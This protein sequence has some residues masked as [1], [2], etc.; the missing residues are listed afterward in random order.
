LRPEDLAIQIPN[1][2][3]S[4]RVLQ[5]KNSH[6]PESA[7]QEGITADTMYRIRADLGSIAGA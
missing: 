3:M 7:D 6:T 5:R 4:T 1:N 2:G